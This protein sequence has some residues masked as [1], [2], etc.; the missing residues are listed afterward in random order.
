M[1]QFL[2]LYFFWRE[3]K[4]DESEIK[5]RAHTVT[6]VTPFEAAYAK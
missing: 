1:K 4:N 2:K 5:M 3:K 6:Q